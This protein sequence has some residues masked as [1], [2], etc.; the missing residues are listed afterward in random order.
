MP[1]ASTSCSSCHGDCRVILSARGT[2][3]EG[4][5]QAI[6]RLGLLDDEAIALDEAALALAH[7]DHPDADLDAYLER[8]CHMAA[9]LMV[10]GA[11][12]HSANDRAAL[13]AE[14]VADE[15]GFRGD[16]ETYDD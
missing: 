8:F 6:A 14:I 2:E 15:H 16:S 12:A 5:S 3:A 4:M 1:R 9:Q 10:R 13:L 11:S 7:L